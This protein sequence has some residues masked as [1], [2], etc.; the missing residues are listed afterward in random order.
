MAEIYL[1]L[2]RVLYWNILMHYQRQKKTHPQNHVHV[3]QFYYFLSDDS[4][5]YD[6]TTTAHSKSLIEL[7]KEGN[8]LVSSLNTIWKKYWC[9]CIAIYMCLGS[10]PSVSYIVLLL[11]YNLSWYQWTWTWKI[12]GW[13]YQWHWKLLY[14]SIN[15]KCSTTGIKNIWFTDF[16]A[17]LH[18]KQWCQS[19]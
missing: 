18:T 9:L 3:I 8:L 12:G 4:K 2:L 7:L 1:C 19:G 6:A 13:W 17:F 5:Q 16:H 10:I 15:V 14:I 11:I